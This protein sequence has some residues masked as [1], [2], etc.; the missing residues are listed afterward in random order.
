VV[1]ASVEVD[2]RTRSKWSRVLRYAAEYKG[3]NESPRD[4]VQRKG[5]INRC[6][7]R[8]ARRLGQGSSY[9]GAAGGAV[10]RTS[11]PRE[12]SSLNCL[13]VSLIGLESTLGAPQLSLYAQV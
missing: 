4:F 12:Q 10:G 7:S 1:A 3:L 11:P 5:G 6:A 2:E 8:L 9:R 13:W